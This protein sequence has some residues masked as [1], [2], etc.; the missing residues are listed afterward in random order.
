L[1]NPSFGLAVLCFVHRGFCARLIFW[2]GSG[3]HDPPPATRNSLRCCAVH[4]DRSERDQ[5]SG[6]A[7]QL[8]LKTHFFL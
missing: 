6:D 5:D 3:R 2:R 1:A 4:V 7:M 8:I